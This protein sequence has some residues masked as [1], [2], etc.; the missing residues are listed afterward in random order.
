MREAASTVSGLLRAALAEVGSVHAASLT[1][2]SFRR[3]GGKHRPG[4]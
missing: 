2:A 4:A 1:L 3:E